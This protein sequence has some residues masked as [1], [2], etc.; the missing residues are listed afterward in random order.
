MLTL[1][2]GSE[3]QG[4]LHRQGRDGQQ[5]IGLAVRQLGQRVGRAGCDHQQ[6]GLVC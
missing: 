3:Q 1:H 6:I 5:R 2:G 4:T